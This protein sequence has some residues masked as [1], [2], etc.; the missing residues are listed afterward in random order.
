MLFILQ[1]IIGWC[2]RYLLLLIIVLSTLKI[3]NI[4]QKWW[5]FD[6]CFKQN[7]NPPF[8][9]VMVFKSKARKCHPWSNSYSRRPYWPFP[10]NVD[11]YFRSTSTLRARSC[12]PLG[13][14]TLTK[15]LTHP[16]L[17]APLPTSW[18]HLLLMN[19][20]MPCSKE[21]WMFMHWQPLRM[22]KT[23]SIACNI[24][25]LVTQFPWSIRWLQPT[26]AFTDMVKHTCERT[27]SSP[28]GHHVG[29][30]RI[31]L[32]DP[33][34][35]GIIAALGDFCFKWGKSLQQWNESCIPWSPRS[36]AAKKSIASE[37][38]H[39]LKWTWT[40]AWVNFLDD[41]WTME[42]GEM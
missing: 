39:L 25:T 30:W 9:R 33:K 2:Q 24:L 37:G 5:H 16:S 3:L 27:S 18:A 4:Q 35:L 36:L 29:H 28:S 1:M 19:T 21:L 22:S 17:L 8:S 20:A 7:A 31:H 12:Y 26:D 23:W 6:N 13:K 34:L 40:C 41:L 10:N 42:F 15:L 38:L 14:P 32:W 11:I